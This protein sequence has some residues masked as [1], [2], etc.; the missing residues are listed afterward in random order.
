MGNQFNTGYLKKHKMAVIAVSVLIVV[1]FTVLIVARSN[2]VKQN[3]QQAAIAEQETAVLEQEQSEQTS[4][5][6]QAV[7]GQEQSEPA[8]DTEQPETEKDQ[9]ENMDEYLDWA[10][11][12]IVENQESLARAGLMQAETQQT[13]SDLS[14]RLSVLEDS[15]LCVEN[16]VDRHAE[17]LAGQ[18]GE[19]AGAISELSTDGQE[20][21]LQIR[22]LSSSVSSLLSDLKTSGQRTLHPHRKDCQDC[23]THCY[24]QKKI[25]RN[26]M[27]ALRKQ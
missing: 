24:R 26:T 10:D 16:L 20:T 27:T 4:A 23:R 13:L 25:Q 19:I 18:N 3:G 15:M 17:N 12:T 14:E 2:K 7:S 9:L 8:S 11:Q 5:V 1:L 22:S 21:I 6:E